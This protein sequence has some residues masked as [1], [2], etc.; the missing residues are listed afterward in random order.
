MKGCL[1]LIIIIAIL[2]CLVGWMF[3]TD[4]LLL[5]ILIAIISFVLIISVVIVAGIAII[6]L[7]TFVIWLL[8]KILW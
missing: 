6:F 4:C 2:T 5:E 7:I 3:S 1:T 8:I